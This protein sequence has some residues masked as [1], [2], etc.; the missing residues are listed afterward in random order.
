MAVDHQSVKKK[1]YQAALPLF[2]ESGYKGATM[3]RIARASGMPLATMQ[4]YYR[5]KSDIFFDLAMTPREDTNRFVEKLRYPVIIGGRVDERYIADLSRIM[6]GHINRH[7]NVIILNLRHSTGTP[8][9]QRSRELVMSIHEI[10]IGTLRQLADRPVIIDDYLNRYVKV[11]VKMIIDLVVTISEY[12]EPGT[13]VYDII[14]DHISDT[15]RKLEV[16]ANRNFFSYKLG[17]MYEK[18]GGNHIGSLKKESWGV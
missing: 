16:L 17:H 5:Q 8:L 13:W 9:E 11:L 6:T 18:K 2:L 3:R 15:F 4:Y 12:Y 14:Y 7:H 1:I 10:V